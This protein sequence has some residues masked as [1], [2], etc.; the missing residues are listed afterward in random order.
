MSTLHSALLIGDWDRATY[1]A[2]RRELDRVLPAM[3]AANIPEAL[4]LLEQE[5][6]IGYLL[7]AQSFPGEFTFRNIQQ[8]QSAAPLARLCV[9]LDSWSEGETRSGHPWPGVPRLYLHQLW[10]R[11]RSENWAA[12]GP[13]PLADWS[14]LPTLAADELWLR[15]AD[16]RLPHLKGTALIWGP[17]PD[18]RAAL[19]DVCRAVGLQA[20]GLQTTDPIP[21]V[22]VRLAL[23]DAAPYRNHRGVDLRMIAS[24]ARR[25]PV[26]ALIDFPRPDEIAEATAAGCTHVLGKPF[27]IDDLV[28]CLHDAL[29]HPHPVC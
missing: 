10:A 1:R 23:Y 28:A 25:V 7:I 2:A 11:L 27:L 26:I 17:E 13:D 29:V 9:L 16:R 22:E 21:S 12:T 3:M 20:I 18:S 6:G 14:T 4:R 5:S 19:S 15:R 8:L 24:R